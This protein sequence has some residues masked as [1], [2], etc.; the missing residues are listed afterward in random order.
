MVMK[1]YGINLDGILIY[2]SLVHVVEPQLETGEI[3]PPEVVISIQRSK[4]ASGMVDAQV[5]R[6][7]R[8]M[9]QCSMIEPLD[10]AFKVDYPADWEYIASRIKRMLT[11]VRTPSP[12]KPIRP[13]APYFGPLPDNMEWQW[14]EWGMYAYFA[15]EES[16]FMK[17]GNG[18]NVLS[19][20]IPEEELHR[21]LLHGTGSEEL[22]TRIIRDLVSCAIFRERRTTW[23]STRATT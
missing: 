2:Y 12:G 1:E 16:G 23:K 21:N 17:L 7:F 9:I 10:Y 8:K 11:E 14:T 15:I 13:K 5:E 18:G 4:E 22:T 19:V 3:G 20:W 6:A